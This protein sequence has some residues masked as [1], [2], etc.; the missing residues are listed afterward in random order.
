MGGCNLYSRCSLYSESCKTQLYAVT[1][2]HLQEM[3]SITKEKKKKERAAKGEYFEHEGGRKFSSTIQTWEA[4]TIYLNSLQVEGKHPGFWITHRKT[5]CIFNLALTQTQEGGEE[6]CQN[7]VPEK[8]RR[9][10][11]MTCKA[12]N[13]H[14]NIIRMA[15]CNYDRWTLSHNHRN[16]Y[17]KKVSDFALDQILNSFFWLQAQLH[18]P[19][20]FCSLKM[21]TY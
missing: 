9:L 21:S 13:S 17:N 19:C 18:A 5:L 20:Y 15:Y 4:E 6:V 10:Q 12:V 11:M 3:K 1:W 2:D 16:N 14:H 8:H 7:D